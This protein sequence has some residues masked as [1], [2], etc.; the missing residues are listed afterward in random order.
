M[1]LEP[2][3]AQSITDQHEP[4][5]D[6]QDRRG[7]L[8][9]VNRL[10]D[11]RHRTFSHWPDH[12]VPGR[13][14]MIVAGFFHCNVADRTICIYCNLICQ[15]WSGCEDEP[16]DV[17]QTLSPHCPYVLSML[18]L[19]GN[20]GPCDSTCATSPDRR[21]SVSEPGI[22]ESVLS[23]LVAAR[24]DL[25]ASQRLLNQNFKLSVIK[26]CWEDQLRLKRKKD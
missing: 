23:R 26:R 20:E 16:S 8:I 25:P 21:S 13:E 11:V 19:A 2:Q 1:F 18:T 24:L 6:G 14:R 4:M 3:R 5:A 17:H 7:R 10:R 15:Q 9:E 22:D 12:I